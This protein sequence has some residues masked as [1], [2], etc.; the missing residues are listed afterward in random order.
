MMQFKR[1]AIVL[2]MLGYLTIAS[3]APSA[4]ATQSVSATDGAVYSPQ[5]P[6]TG[7]LPEMTAPS[8]PAKEL[9]YLVGQSRTVLHTMRFGTE[10]RIEEPGQMFTMEYKASRTRIVI[11]ANAKI[12]R[13]LCG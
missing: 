3:C 8:C 10:V 1:A 9:Q 7:A 5:S 6:L 2:C 12:E 13:V 4:A 11:G